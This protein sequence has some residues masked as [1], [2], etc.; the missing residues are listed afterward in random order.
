M[1]VV[2]L[3][4]LAWIEVTWDDARRAEA[5]SIAFGEGEAHVRV[6]RIAA[7]GE[8]GEHRTGSGQLFVPVQGSGWVRE[9][10]QRADVEVGE[11]AYLPRGVVHSKGSDDGLGLNRSGA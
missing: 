5:A 9:G 11:V 7:D 4:A 1:E 6:L 10:D 8:V 2:D 3:S